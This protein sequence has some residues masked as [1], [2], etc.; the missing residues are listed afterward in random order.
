[1]PAAIE[2][3]ARDPDSSD[4]PRYHWARAQGSPIGG[5]GPPARGAI[6]ASLQAGRQER[7][8]SNPLRSC[9]TLRQPFGAKWT[10]LH[11]PCD[12]GN[13]STASPIGRR[14]PGSHGPAEEKVSALRVNISLPFVRVAGSSILSFLPAS[15]SPSR[16]HTRPLRS[17]PR[18]VGLPDR[19]GRSRPAVRAR[20]PNRRRDALRHPIKSAAAGRRSGNDSRKSPAARELS[21]N[22]LACQPTARHEGPT[23]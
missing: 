3:G 4:V 21:S 17:K 1:M 12:P 11:G 16:C 5:C 9:L 15:G 10:M 2:M 19:A 14:F 18:F 20:H 23:R 8:R 6:R 22:F 7:P 13:P